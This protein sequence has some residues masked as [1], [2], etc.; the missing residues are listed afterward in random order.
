MPQPKSAAC[1]DHHFWSTPLKMPSKH[2][3]QTRPS[4]NL[5]GTNLEG[6]N[7]KDTNLRGRFSTLE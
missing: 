2:R 5:Q 3:D 1:R 7:L 4:S 6:A